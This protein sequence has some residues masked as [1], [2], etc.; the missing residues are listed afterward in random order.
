MNKKNISEINNDL[1]L[2]LFSLELFFK[3]DDIENFNFAKKGFNLE[4]KS[5]EFS[6]PNKTLSYEDKFSICFSFN[7]NLL[8]DLINEF[9]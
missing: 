8:N 3:I 5:V 6:I 7:F 2:I 4:E 9:I 1:S